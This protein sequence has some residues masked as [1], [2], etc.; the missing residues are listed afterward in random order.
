MYTIIICVVI[1]AIV[2]FIIEREEGVWFLGI[3]G[4]GI[5]GLAIGMTISLFIPA[6]S[7]VETK[8]YNM[9]AIQDNSSVKGSFFLGSGSINGTMK[10]VYYYMEDSNSYRMNQVD[11]DKAKV[12][13][14]SEPPKV[15]IYHLTEDVNT[16]RSKFNTGGLLRET[17]WYEFYIPKGSI[18]N[19]FTL[20]AK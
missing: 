8:T 12:I 13:Y 19:N 7:K 14:S 17:E 20:D 2:G 4:G 18:Q 1:C 11:Y 9:A 3:I 5:L 16:L 15:I 10:Y 6:I